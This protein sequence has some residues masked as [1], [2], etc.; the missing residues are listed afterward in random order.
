[1]KHSI[2]LI[3]VLI[4][5]TSLAL[6]APKLASSET[7]IPDVMKHMVKPPAI[8]IANLRDPFE[9][10]LTIVAARKKALL[11]KQTIRKSNRKPEFLESFDLSTLKLVAT[12][13]MGSERVAMVEDSRG[14]GYI[15]RRGN[16]MGKNNGRIEKLTEDTI[17]L[18]E[19]II[20]PAGE[21]LD[22]QVTLTMKEVN[23]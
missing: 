17:F 23:E 7:T 19:Q 14:R 4:M 22:R 8:D 13:N 1:M 12:F 10:Y 20:N 21:R 9:S 11:V 5:T 2:W 15:V 16:Y 6:A 3:P 18:L